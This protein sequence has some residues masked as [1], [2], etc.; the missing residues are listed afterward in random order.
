MAPVVDWAALK[1]KYLCVCVS[2]CAKVF[3]VCVFVSVYVWF[4]QLLRVNAN[5]QEVKMNAI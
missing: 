4:T 1:I 5:T 2:V 3:G